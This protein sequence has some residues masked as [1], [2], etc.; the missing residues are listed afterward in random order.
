MTPGKNLW[1][2]SS[3]QIGGGP[4][5]WM[6]KL[7]GRRPP[8]AVPAR[9]TP[10]ARRAACP[11]PAPADC[12]PG[13]APRVARRPRVVWPG[14]AVRE[15]SPEL[16][17]PR[18]ARRMLF[19][20]FGTSTLATWS[21]RLRD[22]RRLASGLRLRLRCGA[23]CLLRRWCGAR[24]RLRRPSRLRLWTLG[25][26]SRDRRTLELLLLRRL[27]SV[28]LLGRI[29]LRAIESL[30]GAVELRAWLSR[31]LLQLRTRH[32]LLHL[33]LRALK[34]VLAGFNAHA[35]VAASVRTSW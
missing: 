6:M 8:A 31:I 24:R 16:R 19:I 26:R 33:C 28:E 12:V 14:G 15:R 3:C 27:R 17:P 9:P 7:K 25:L 5:D 30:L 13:S 2:C 4:I 10:S 22:G 18:S 11:A 21:R 1:H 29:A 20:G 34:R 35:L 32:G 23:R